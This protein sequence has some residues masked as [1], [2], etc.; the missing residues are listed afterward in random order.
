MKRAFGPFECA[1][2]LALIALA[3][4]GVADTLLR[5]A[6]TPPWVQPVAGVWT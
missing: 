3:A 5:R 1:L 4:W 6:A 2:S